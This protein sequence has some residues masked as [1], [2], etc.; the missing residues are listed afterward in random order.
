VCCFCLSLLFLLKQEL[1]QS[2]SCFCLSKNNSKLKQ[3]QSLYFLLLLACLLAWF[4]LSKCCDCFC[5]SKNSK[6]KQKHESIAEKATLCMVLLKQNHACNC[7]CLSKNS[8]TAK[9]LLLEALPSK[10]FAE[11]KKCK[12]KRSN[13]FTY[14]F[15]PKHAGS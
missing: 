12:T 2:F 4:C 13:R 10:A 7:F 5:L 15:F 8:T 9:A 11:V 14:R 6:L 3:K 1:K